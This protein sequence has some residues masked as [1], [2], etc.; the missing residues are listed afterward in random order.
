MLL[1]SNSMNFTDILEYFKENA[2]G[3]VIGA[4]E[5]ELKSFLTDDFYV[6]LIKWN[7]DE[8]FSWGTMSKKSNRIRKSS[9]LNPKLT[10]K[11][12]RR[13]DY[14]MLNKIYG[15]ES[16]HLFRFLTQEV[17]RY[18]EDYIKVQN[19]QR[20]CYSKVLGD[21]RDEI[22]RN[23]YTLFKGTDWYNSIDKK[24]QDDFN[25]FFYKVYLNKSRHPLN[26]R[27]TFFYGDCLE[28][29]FLRT[30]G[31]GKLETSV[32]KILDVKF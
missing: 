21:N 18:H 28:P 7:Q 11:Y 2:E 8:I 25:E 19:S 24:L 16:V 13:V 4:T 27:R 15:L 23:I 31:R 6:Y 29:K 20:F 12:D 32:E 14:L 17:S 3:W 22:S 26:P 30:I 9:L 5:S 10:G 1:T